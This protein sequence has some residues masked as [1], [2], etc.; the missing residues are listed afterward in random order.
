[1]NKKE[2]R[3]ILNNKI[4][5]YFNKYT[6]VFLCEEIESLREAL[7]VS[8]CKD[9]WYRYRI[10][11]VDKK[12]KKNATKKEY[13]ELLRA[14]I[15]DNFKQIIDRTVMES[16]YYGRLKNSFWKRLKFLFTKKI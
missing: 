3:K 15:N 7:G 6:F 8:I 14:I 13:K 11:Y 10:G 4:L 12:F 1:M 9:D 5:D 16:C 2:L